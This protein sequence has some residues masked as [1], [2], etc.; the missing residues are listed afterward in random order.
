MQKIALSFAACLLA[1][2]ATGAHAQ[3]LW[4]WRDASGQMHISDKAPPAG[5][6][7][8]NIISSPGGAAPAAAP[9]LTPLGAAPAPGDARAAAAEPAA[10][11]STA[12]ES[13]LDKK[14]KA[15]DKDKADKEKADRAVVDAKN[16][17]I[18]KDNCT[19]AQAALPGIQ[20]GSRIARVNA[21]G[22]REVLDDA[23][24]AQEL[25]RTQEVISTNCGAQ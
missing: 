20:N 17:A 15:A 13:A 6:P 16:A 2:A 3:G 18:R 7:A 19:R 11:A 22:E 8:K 21:N 9:V 24:R 23:G 10:A 14:K 4:K 25:K 12:S 1:L 5:T